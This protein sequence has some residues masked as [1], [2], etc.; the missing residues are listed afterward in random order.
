MEPGDRL[1]HLANRAS[2]EREV[3]RTEHGF[4]ADRHRPEPER[5]IAIE[6]RVR[7]SDD[8]EP[9]AMRIDDSAQLGEEVVDLRVVPDRIA[10]DEGRSRHDAIGEER[11]A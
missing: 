10:A 6:M 7:R 8:R 4:L 1:A 5:A 9:P 11:A 2:F 3:T